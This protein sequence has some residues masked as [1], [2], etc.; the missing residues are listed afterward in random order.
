MLWRFFSTGWVKWV[1]L[2]VVLLWLANLILRNDW[3]NLGVSV[4]SMALVFGIW[5]WLF[6]WI[7]RRTFQR[8]P[9]LQY[10]IRYVF[11][12]EEIRLSTQNAEAVLSW[13]TFQKAEELSE[14]FLLY[15]N[16]VIANPIIKKGFTSQEDMERFRLLLR[17]KGLLK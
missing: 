14:F 8:T 2:G 6:G 4:A 11:S 17:N 16:K 3:M 13:D 1:Y 15:Q 12:P 9:A 10:A 5:W 7:S